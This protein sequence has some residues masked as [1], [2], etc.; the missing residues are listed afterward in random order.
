[1]NQR[2]IVSIVAFIFT[3]WMNCDCSF[4]QLL[5]QQLI[6]TAL[7]GR[8]ENVSDASKNS[9][10]TVQSSSGRVFMEGQE[11]RDYRA[12]QMIKTIGS[13][14]AFTDTVVVGAVPNDTLVITGA[15]FNNGPI[16]VLNN[17]VLI[18]QNATATILGDVFVV[19]DGQLWASGST[20]FF[21]QQYFYQRTWIIINNGYVNI[22]DC[23]LDFSGLS[24]SLAVSDSGEI[25]MHQI[26]NNGFTTA[27]AY[28]NGSI[29]IDSTNQAGE[30]ILTDQATFSFN[31]VHTLLL[32]HHI[33]SGGIVNTTFPSGAFVSN[34]AFN[35]TLPGVSGVNFDLQVDSSSDVMWALMPENGSDVTVT[36]SVIRSI[37]NWFTNGDTVTVSG[38][39]NNSS[40]TSFTA[41]LADR[42]LQ[43]NNTSVQTW[44]LYVF[45]SSSI[46]VT[47]CIIGE[48]G[49]LGTSRCNTQNVFCDG[50]GGYFWASDQSFCVGVGSSVSSYVRSEKNGILLYGYGTVNGGA[51]ALNSSVLITVQ[52]SLPAD[53]VPYDN[54]IAWM[55]R[56]DQPAAAFA[57]SVVEIPGSAWIDQGPL[58]NWMD[59]DR[60]RLW[61]APASQNPPQ[62]IAITPEIFAEVRNNTLG[63]WD[64]H[65]LL[66]GTYSVRLNTFNNAGDSIE[67]VKQLTLLPSVLGIGEPAAITTESSCY[68]NPA[69]HN[70]TLVS[71]LL[72][73]SAAA[74]VIV[75]SEGK[76]LRNLSVTKMSDNEWVINLQGK[77]AG[78]YFYRIMAGNKVATGEIHHI[79]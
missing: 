49:T 67:A 32:W 50:S 79:R 20:L 55:I 36:G 37:G 69:S 43:L 48:L 58:A 19:Q 46:N 54:S 8:S 35:N 2:R 15:F 5:P 76:E 18:F 57:D 28:S 6:N 33:P 34:Y 17:G 62:W 21:P 40:Y 16:I 13:R 3:C 73:Q 10:S 60:Y 44:S 7:S 51:S 45:D 47:G 27:G 29:S 77:P 26:T 66:P 53:P 59:M 24:H 31:K 1:M 39:V 74:L 23:T 38:L 4:A 63:T 56:V 42:N 61:Y 52:S 71:E 11:S 14:T 12:R 25:A 41:P 72:K 30:F 75:N 65:G 22:D 78:T 64:T 68:P 9:Q 70:I